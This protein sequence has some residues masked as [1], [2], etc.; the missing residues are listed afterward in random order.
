MINFVDRDRELATLKMEK[1]RQNFI[2]GH[3]TYVYED[4]CRRQIYQILNRAGRWWG[5]KELTFLPSCRKR[6]NL[7]YGEM[8]VGTNIFAF[9]VNPVFQMH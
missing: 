5:T 2:D 3:M 7:F 6:Q 4:I 1:I 9:S 8:T